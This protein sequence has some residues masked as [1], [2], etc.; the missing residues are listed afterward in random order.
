MKDQQKHIKDLSEIRNMMERASKFISLSGISGISAGIVA[1][2]GAFLA[3][4]HLNIYLPGKIST[5]EASINYNVNNSIILLFIIAMA[6]FISAFTLAVIFT[7]RNS[8]K[9]RLP[10][11]D[12]TSK[13]LLFN[14]FIP[15]FVGFLFILA[16]IYYRYFLLI[17]PSSLVFYG[18]SLINAGHFTFRDIKILGYLEMCL[19]LISLIAIEWGLYIW[20]FGFGVLHIVYGSIMYF[21][22]EK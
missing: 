3:W 9:K 20:A 4:W 15:I 14:L 6:T 2:A 7:T 12:H 16:L 19:G 17:I 21:K 8:K 22:Y 11:W 10:I 18:L 5:S 13:R 1:L